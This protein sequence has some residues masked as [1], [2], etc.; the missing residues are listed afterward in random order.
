MKQNRT[1]REPKNT[2]SKSLRC[3]RREEARNKKRNHD[4][5]TLAIFS[6]W[7][8][9][10]VSKSESIASPIEVAKSTASLKNTS[11]ISAK[12]FF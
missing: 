12:F 1:K 8:I 7:S 6:S 3:L 10:E 4:A 11:S 9:D 5:W 2:E